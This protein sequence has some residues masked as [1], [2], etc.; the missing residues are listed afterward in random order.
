MIIHVCPL[1]YP[2]LCS[3]N[4]TQLLLVYLC[5][6][7]F[8]Y[9]LVSGQKTY[10]VYNYIPYMHY[11]YCATWT[12]IGFSLLL[13]KWQWS[14]SYICIK[15]GGYSCKHGSTLRSL[16]VHVVL[17]VVSHSNQTVFRQ[18]LWTRDQNQLI[19]YSVTTSVCV[20]YYIHTCTKLHLLYN[21]NIIHVAS[22]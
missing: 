1:V 22:L 2:K 9:Q 20:L 7:L 14:W 16:Y 11:Q 5:L 21:N 12:S 19:N 15:R 17:P 13:S 10:S 3:Y 8:I 18:H 4:N 6:W